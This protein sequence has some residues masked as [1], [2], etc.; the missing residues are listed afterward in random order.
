MSI[1]ALYNAIDI[2][3]KNISHYAMYQNL[4]QI[5]PKVK[6]DFVMYD[7]FA[8]EHITYDKLSIE[9]RERRQDTEF[10]KNV[11]S[12]YNNECIVSGTDM[13]CQICHIKPFNECTEN[14]R[15]DTNNGMILRDDIH[16]LFDRREIKINPNTLMIE[17]SFFIMNNE[18]RCEY[19]KFNG[20][21][22]NIDKKSIPYLH[23]IYV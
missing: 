18:K 11:R 13:P 12:R 10:K 21:K 23:H 2:S 14:E 7:L 4:T 1:C 5:Y 22:I 3:P 8:Y 19:H 15:Y 20:M 6:V 9:E 17:V 16:T